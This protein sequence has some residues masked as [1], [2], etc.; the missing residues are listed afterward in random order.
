MDKTYSA[1]GEKRYAYGIDGKA[2][3]KEKIRKTK[4]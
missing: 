1:Y 4:T 2:R 3:K